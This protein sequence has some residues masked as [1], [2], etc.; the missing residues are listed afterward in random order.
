MMNTRN[1]FIDTAIEELKSAGFNVSKP[2][3]ETFLSPSYSQVYEDI[4]VE[5]LLRGICISNDYRLKELYYIEIGANNPIGTSNTYLF[6]R[7]Y[8]M[9][10]ILVE[11]NKFLCDELASVRPEDIIINR[12]VVCNN[13]ESST[14]YI[15]DKNEISSIYSNFISEWAALSN[16]LVHIQKTEVVKNCRIND[17]FHLAQKP[18]GV[19]SI[20]IE[21]LD[22]EILLDLDI[23]TFRPFIIIIEPSDFFIKD[24]TQN[25]ILFMKTKEYDLISMTDVNLIFKDSRL[26]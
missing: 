26:K 9:R 8:E 11:A 12:V 1:I 24:N 4:I 3:I 7:K 17:I 6:Y 20:D 19:L 5:S 25:M 16:N 2:T 22:M 18:V 15:S 23:D 21:G 13:D 14:L 10:G